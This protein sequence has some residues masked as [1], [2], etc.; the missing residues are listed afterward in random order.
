MVHTIDMFCKSVRR[1][2]HLSEINAAICRN[3]E[4]CLDLRGMTE[5]LCIQDEEFLRA[6][7]HFN[8]KRIEMDFH[9]FSDFIEKNQ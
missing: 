9:E 4:I 6:I 3:G 2:V 5:D 7:V 8:D 1:S